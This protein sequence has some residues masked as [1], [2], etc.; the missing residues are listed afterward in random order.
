MV[1]RAGGVVIGVVFACLSL[2]PMAGLQ[3][4]PD[5]AVQNAE[6]PG[7]VERAALAEMEFLVGDW[8]GEGWGLRQTGERVRF[9]VEE[10]FHYRGDK[11]LMDMQGIFGDV[12]E[13]GTR[14]PS[15]EYNLGILYYDRAASRY[16]MWHYSSSGE[17]FTTPMT[18]DIP[19]RSMHYV[20][21]YPG[22]VTGRFH[23]VVG[24]DGVWTSSFHI[25][26]EDGSWRQVMEFRRTRVG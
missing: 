21:E 7:V 24:L 11:D 4:A 17:V 20:K 5:D 1:R 3:A 15:R 19:G 25:L 2:V 23:L 22:G 6:L 18:V 16:V 14:S 9:W 10:A 8:A 13:D 12:L 26:Q